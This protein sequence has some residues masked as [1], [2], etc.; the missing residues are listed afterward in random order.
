MDDLLSPAERRLRSQLEQLDLDGIDDAVAEPLREVL[1][2]YGFQGDAGDDR[3]A[4]AAA[5]S[6]TQRPRGRGR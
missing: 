1:R 2:T 5:L 6:R 3:G 4:E